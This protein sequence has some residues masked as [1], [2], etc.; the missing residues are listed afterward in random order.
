VVLADRRPIAA[1]RAAIEAAL[2]TL[3]LA[4]QLVDLFDVWLGEPALPGQV[5]AAEY[6]VRL[7]PPTSEA[8]AALE[9]G[10][11]R[12]VASSALPRSRPKGDRTVQ[13]D[14][15][16]LLDA[17]GVQLAGDETELAIRTRFDPARGV[18]RPEEVIAALSD[19][20]RQTLGI[21]S[22]VR[23]RLILATDVQKL[24]L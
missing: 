3:P 14:L 11:R 7:E 18:G 12:L 9:A 21:G 4:V 23:S 20:I 8:A 17:V 15:R 13:Y 5:L 16:P 2:S 19:E 24:T 1:V 6:A 22:I 10:C